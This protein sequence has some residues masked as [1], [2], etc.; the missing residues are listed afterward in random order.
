MKNA[1][2][3]FLENVC[4][5]KGIGTSPMEYSTPYGAKF[6][7]G[8]PMREKFHVA[9]LERVNKI[10]GLTGDEANFV[11]GMAVITTTIGKFPTK[12]DACSY[13]G[14]SEHEMNS[15]L[16]K[17]VNLAW[18]NDEL[19]LKHWFSEG[20]I[21]TKPKAK[22]MIYAVAAD[23]L[24]EGLTP[25][26]DNDDCSS[27]AMLKTM[28]CPQLVQSRAVFD[29]LSVTLEYLGCCERGFNTPLPVFLKMRYGTLRKYNGL[30]AFAEL[31]SENNP[32]SFDQNDYS[33]VIGRLREILAV[34]D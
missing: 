14:M 17:S 28:L 23:L 2:V 1:R 21:E 18:T 9:A 30:M 29:G 8:A 19:S 16:Q 5:N 20:G 6:K 4:Y 11:L 32:E 10:T 3:D 22:A 12:V 24:L 13:I 27:R 33:F 25:D 26:A 31:I 34:C 15:F 7:G